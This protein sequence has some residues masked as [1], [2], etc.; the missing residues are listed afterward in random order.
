MLPL[1]RPDRIHITFD[2]RRLV[3]IAGLIIPVAMSIWEMHWV[4]RMRET[5][6]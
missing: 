5:S 3:A 1:E 6:C 4:G 2:Y